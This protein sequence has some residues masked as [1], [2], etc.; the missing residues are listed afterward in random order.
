M[1]P[2]IA[3]W[4]WFGVAWAFILAVIF[5]RWFHRERVDQARTEEALKRTKPAT[6]DE[7]IWDA[8]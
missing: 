8:V 3:V 5:K 2:H 4:V 1:I 6:D 7:H